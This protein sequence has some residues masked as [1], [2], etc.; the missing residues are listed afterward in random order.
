[1]SDEF[2][3]DFLFYRRMEPIQN[4]TISV[5]NHDLRLKE[6]TFKEV[7]NVYRPRFIDPRRKSVFTVIIGLNPG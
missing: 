6:F 2:C 7:G 5:P 4:D 3:V 1:M